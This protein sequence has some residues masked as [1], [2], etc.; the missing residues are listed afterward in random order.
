MQLDRGPAL[1][2]GRKGRGSVRRIRSQAVRDSVVDANK[3]SIRL[4]LD[5]ARIS[6]WERAAATGAIW[7]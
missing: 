4:F 5:T 2:A 6:E 7:G 1:Q 3:G